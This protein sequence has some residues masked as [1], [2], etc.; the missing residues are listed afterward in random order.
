M[1]L[2]VDELAT[3]QLLGPADRQVLDQINEFATA[4]IAA[5]RIAFCVFVRQD[6]ALRLHGRKGDDIFR[7]DQFDLVLLAM[8]FLTDCRGQ[9]RIAVTQ[10]SG[11]EC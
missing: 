10:V 8:E 3:E 1:G 6:G 2:H 5:A 11:E 9:F 4:I 7:G